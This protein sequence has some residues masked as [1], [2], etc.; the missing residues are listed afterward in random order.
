MYICMRACMYICMCNAHRRRSR[1]YSLPLKQVVGSGRNVAFS[2]QVALHPKK[3]EKEGKKAVV[4]EKVDPL[5]S[6]RGR[7][8]QSGCRGPGHRSKCPMPT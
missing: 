2:Q 8:L 6:C 7:A 4:L 3:Q 5:G 1:A